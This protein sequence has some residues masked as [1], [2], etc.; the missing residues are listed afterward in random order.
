MVLNSFLGLVTV[1]SMGLEFANKLNMKPIQVKD[2]MTIAF[3][4]A[5]GSILEAPVA[6][7]LLMTEQLIS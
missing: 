7:T 4:S 6:G 5:L 2:L 3:G 1:A